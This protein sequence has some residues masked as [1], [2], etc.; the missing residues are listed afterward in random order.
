MIYISLTTVPDRMNFEDSARI[1]LTSLLNQKTDK[2]YKVLYNVP[3]KYTGR[4]SDS[5][6]RLPQNTEDGEVIE[7]PEWVNKLAEEND[8]LVIHRTKDYG[9]PTKIVGG[10]LYTNNPD[11]ILICCD[12]DQEYHEEMLEYHV[13]KRQQYPNAAIAFRGDRLHEKREWIE[14]GQKKF[15]YLSMPDNFPVMYDVNLSITGHWHS[16]SYKRSLFGKDFLNEDFLFNYHWSDDIIVAYYFAKNNIEIKCVKWDKETD[17]RLVNYF[18]RSCNSFPV[19]RNLP[20][21][22]TG[23]HVLRNITGAHVNDQATYPQEW[24]HFI[25]DHYSKIHNG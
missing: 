4:L 11:D 22:A 25:L 19:V 16:V 6:G 17:F 8:R 3:F 15:M 13:Y 21:H 1:N 20:F 5:N 2:E 7:I 23:C 12:D 18:G 9:P 10:L 24:V 14:D